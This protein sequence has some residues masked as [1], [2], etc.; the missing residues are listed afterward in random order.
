MSDDPSVLV[1]SDAPV[2]PSPP[3]TLFAKLNPLNQSSE[4]EPTGPALGSPT[5]QL[6]SDAPK[7]ASPATSSQTQPKEGK[8]KS[9]SPPVRQSIDPKA[10]QLAL[11]AAASPESVIQEQSDKQTAS[12]PPAPGDPSSAPAN[13]QADD[14]PVP[15]IQNADEYRKMLEEGAEDLPV[16]GDP[17]IAPQTQTVVPQTPPVAKAGLFP[18]PQPKPDDPRTSLHVNEVDVRKVFEMLSREHA[19]NILVSPNVQGT[20]TAD[21]SNLTIEQLLDAVLKSCNLA[22]KTEDNIVYIYTPQELELHSQTQGRED[23]PV[24]IRVYQLNYVRSTDLEKLVRPFLSP[25]GKMT[26]TPASQVGIRVLSQMTTSGGGSGGA[27]GGGSGG[28]AGGGGGGR[29][30]GATSITGGD[31]LPEHEAIIV[32]DHLSVLAKIDRVIQELDVQPPQVLIEAVIVHVTHE[33]T[34]ELG[35]NWGLADSTGQVASILGNG[36]VINS[37]AGFSPLTA[38]AEGAVRGAMAA[39][40]Q[41]MKFGYTGGNAT[42]FIRAL[43]RVGKVDVLATPRL[44]VLNKQPAELQLGERLGY[45]TLSQNLVS[46]TQQIDFLDVG[47]LLRVRPFISTDGM[48]RMEVH[49]ERSRG[50]IVEG[51]PQASTQEV[52]TNVIVPNGATLVIGGLMDREIEMRQSGL[53]W[54]SKL[55]V[56]GALFRYRENRYVKKEL[57]VLLTT[58]IWDP[59]EGPTLDACPPGNEPEEV[60]TGPLADPLLSTP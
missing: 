39:P 11:Q 16:P 2:A 17:T 60:V 45:S 33:N 57:I 6:N 43:E 18:R 5:G 23:D 47:T 49:P 58:R 48:V 35:V 26:A 7:L 12:A 9:T 22:A 42:T 31:S 1:E 37:A 21:L 50:S 40:D 20:V 44:L 28:G 54:L 36:A 55:P 34:R 56:V 46:T 52:T 53:P 4:K 27:G 24:D 3:K 38:V 10:L 32:Q 15:E 25:E 51:V 41:G 13:S 8:N 59:R 30:G 29:G 14:R 19:L